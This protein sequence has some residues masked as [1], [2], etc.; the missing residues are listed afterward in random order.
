MS[1]SKSFF[2]DNV[3]YNEL[4]G[5][6]DDNVLTDELGVLCADALSNVAKGK[7]L[8]VEEKEEK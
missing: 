2:F 4:A 1:S 6:Q 7:S 8:Q 3:H 5:N